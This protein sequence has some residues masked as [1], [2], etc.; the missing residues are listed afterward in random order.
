LT[1][2]RLIAS[3]SDS[4]TSI[5]DNEGLTAANLWNATIDGTSPADSAAGR[6][7][8]FT[9]GTNRNFVL[10]VSGDGDRPHPDKVSIRAKQ[11]HQGEGENATQKIILQAPNVQEVVMAKLHTA[12]LTDEKSGNARMCGFASVR[13]GQAGRTQFALEPIAEFTLK[14]ASVALGLDHTVILTDQGD[15]YTFGELL[16]PCP[17]RLFKVAHARLQASII[18]DNWDMLLILLRKVHQKSPCSFHQR[19]YMP[20]VKISSKALLPVATT[21]LAILMNL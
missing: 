3:R 15:V 5:K 8:L 7:E 20:C 13:L 16:V 10:G 4:D 11:P 12:I 17:A 6:Q 14:V 21:L 19:E 18:M 1:A 9:W 2:A